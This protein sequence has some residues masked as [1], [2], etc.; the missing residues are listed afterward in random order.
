MAGV[1][2]VVFTTAVHLTTVVCC[3]AVKAGT[4]GL[5]QKFVQHMLPR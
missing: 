2:H 4:A 5:G 3:Y 1:A